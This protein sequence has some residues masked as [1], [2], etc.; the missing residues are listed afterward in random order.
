M[1]PVTGPPGS[2][3]WCIHH[4]IDNIDSIACCESCRVAIYFAWTD[5]RKN[6]RMFSSVG[7]L[8]LLNTFLR[9]KRRR[10]SWDSHE[11]HPASSRTYVPSRRTQHIS[12]QGSPSQQPWSVATHRCLPRLGWKWRSPRTT[13]KGIWGAAVVFKNQ[14]LSNG[15]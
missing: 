5:E 10:I 13:M 3:C 14:L 1:G 2:S 7:E 4:K 6:I 8:N 9:N 12:R 15:Q 11:R